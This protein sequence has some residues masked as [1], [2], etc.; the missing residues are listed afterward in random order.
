MGFQRNTI[1]EFEHKERS[2]KLLAKRPENREDINELFFLYNDIL[3]P[4]KQ[5]KNCATCR[6]YVWNRLKQYYGL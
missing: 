1:S 4:R 5:D 2:L 3:L 6:A